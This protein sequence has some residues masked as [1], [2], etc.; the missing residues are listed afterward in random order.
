M[1]IIIYY[2]CYHTTYNIT[3]YTRCGFPAVVAWQRV[4]VG[5]I[6]IFILSIVINNNIIIT[7]TDIGLS[8]LCLRTAL[9]IFCCGLNTII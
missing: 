4:D 2:I 5:T 7:T 1:F 6:Y 8:L 3:I 9:F